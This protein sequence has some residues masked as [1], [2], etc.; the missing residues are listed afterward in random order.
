M[1][2]APITPACKRCT[3]LRR[4]R[5]HPDLADDLSRIETEGRRAKIA[6]ELA[7]IPG[8]VGG[9]LPLLT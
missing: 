7:L 1:A 3:E 4:Y 5:A 2:C 9:E 6:A 8:E